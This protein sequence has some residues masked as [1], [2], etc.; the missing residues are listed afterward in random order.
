MNYGYMKEMRMGYPYGRP[1]LLCTLSRL[2][3]EII[4]QLFDGQKDPKMLQVIL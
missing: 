4:K 3:P 1:L 2:W